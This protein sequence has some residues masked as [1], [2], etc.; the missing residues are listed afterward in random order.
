MRVLLC[1]ACVLTRGLEASRQ[2]TMVQEDSPHK[3]SQDHS[4]HEEKPFSDNNVEHLEQKPV[5]RS[6]K[7]KH[8]ST[9]N[10]IDYD[11]DYDLD[12]HHNNKDSLNED[13]QDHL[14][15]GKQPA[16]NDNMENLEPLNSFIREKHTGSDNVKDD[17]HDHDHD[18]HH[19][20]EE[21]YDTE[22]VS[23]YQMSLTSW[24]KDLLLTDQTGPINDDFHGDHTIQLHHD[25]TGLDQHQHN[26]NDNDHHEPPALSLTTWLV[27]LGS[28]AVISLVS[29]APAIPVTCLTPGRPRH[30]SRRATS[31]GQTQAR[32][33]PLP[34]HPLHVQG[35][36]ALPPG[37]P[38]YR[39]PP[40]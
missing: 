11:Q 36:P 2:V 9:D 6:I 7:E 26:D 35:L 17:D 12:H 24:L 39:H 4:T 3:D 10:T 16:N 18:H 14:T 23:E 28:I 20:D 21:E 5:N 38:G 32:P 40:G 31:T 25:H 19:E 1:V 37:L 29:S 22:S 15:H 33:P 13:S 8:T 34:Q 27:S 30:C